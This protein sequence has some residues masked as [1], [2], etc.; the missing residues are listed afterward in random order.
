MPFKEKKW[1]E[2]VRKTEIVTKNPIVTTNALCCNEAYGFCGA[3]SF[4]FQP[5]VS[6][7]SEECGDWAQCYPAFGAV[8]ASDASM[9]RRLESARRS[10]GQL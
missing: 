3:V 1:K 6:E 9:G 4:G 8:G 2:V 10:F 7:P 5:V